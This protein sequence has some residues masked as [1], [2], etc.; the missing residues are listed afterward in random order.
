MICPH[1]H[2]MGAGLI[3]S[4]LARALKAQNLCQTLSIYD[5]S[6]DHR[7]LCQTHHIGD[8]VCQDITQEVEKADIVVLC[9]PIG[10]FGNIA[11]HIGPHLKKGAILTDV[12]SV[13]GQI[14][15]DILPFLPPDTFFVP[16]HP[17]AGTEFSGPLHGFAELFVQRWC[18]LTPIAQ[19][20]PQ[21]VETL[22]KLWQSCGMKVKNMSPEEHDLVL[23]LTSHLPHLIAYTIV[24]TAVDLQDDVKH[25]VI[26]LSAGG[27]R[28][29]TRIAASDPTMWRDIFLKNKE[30]VLDI[31]SRF[32]KDLEILKSAIEDGHGNVLF[33]HFSRTS[34][35]RK[36]VVEAK[37]DT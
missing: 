27:F 5:H 18:I 23:G 11:Q 25:D 34:S 21:A 9:T 32:T 10:T 28:D 6:P 4:S 7:H 1:I 3:G 14:V 22:T 36:A 37:Q 26:E 20:S 29:F 16:G 2:I 24:G 12:G 31:L 30:P 35:I 8:I 33:E 15:A 17:V 13:K 19:S